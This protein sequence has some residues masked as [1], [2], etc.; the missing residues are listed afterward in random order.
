MPNAYLALSRLKEA[1][2]LRILVTNQPDVAHGYMEEE[3]WRKIHKKVVDTLGFDDVLM[4]RHTKA[5]NCPF[6]KP[7]PMM[8]LAAADKWGIDLFKSW[9]IGDT[10]QD[11]QTG[12]A[13]RCRTLLIDRPHNS[14]LTDDDYYFRVFSLMEAVDK[15]LEKSKQA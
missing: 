6:K 7:S 2:F 9:M 3:V 4:C 13:A 14:A 5:D 8:L 10:G 11:M 12:R 15:I 1:G